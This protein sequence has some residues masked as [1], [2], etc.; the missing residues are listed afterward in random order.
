MRV[1]VGA[2][3]RAVPRKRD[4]RECG[5]MKAKCEDCNVNHAMH[6][7]RNGEEVQSLCEVCLKDQLYDLVVNNESIAFEI[8][9]ETIGGR[10]EAVITI[11]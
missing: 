11:A 9:Q 6:I 8:R 1:P 4:R 10:S 7:L 5:I 2:M 3:E